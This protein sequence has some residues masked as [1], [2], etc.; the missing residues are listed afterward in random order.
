MAKPFPLQTLLDL[1]QEGSDAAAARLGAVNG[2]ERDMGERLRVLLEYRGEYSQR[3]ARVTQSGMHSV[4]LRN[5]REFVERIDAAIALQR[6][7]VAKAKSEVET[8]KRHWASEQRKLKSFDALLQ[9]HCSA[10]RISEARQEQK[11]QDDLAMKGFLGRRTL[12]G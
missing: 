11:E 2:H 1:A 12:A 7:L 6:E 9:R 10:A 4:D 3:L 5:F 8:G